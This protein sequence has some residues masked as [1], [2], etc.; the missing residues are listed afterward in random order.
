MCRVGHDWSDLACMHAYTGEGNGNPLQYSSLENP[1]DR[2]AWWAAVYGVPQS[3][4]RME[5][6]S[7]SSS[8]SVYVSAPNVLEIGIFIWNLMILKPYSKKKK[9]AKHHFAWQLI[10]LKQLPQY[11]MATWLWFFSY[12]LGCKKDCRYIS[13]CR[14]T[15]WPAVSWLCP[16]LS[17]IRSFS[18]ITKG[19]STSIV[20]QSKFQ[21]AQMPRS[22]ETWRSYFQLEATFPTQILR[23][24]FMSLMIF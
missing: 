2:G 8:S 11:N 12:D 24:F 18:C 6:L 16:V 1:R 3:R 10:F 13:L 7:S 17:Y 22:P 9:K 19:F 15:G 14:Q 20:W 4:T 23:A 21:F 5:R